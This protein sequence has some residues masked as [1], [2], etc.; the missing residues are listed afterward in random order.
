ML[1]PVSSS[2]QPEVDEERYVRAV[3]YVR[4]TFRRY[5]SPSQRAVDREIV[6]VLKKHEIQLFSLQCLVD[7]VRV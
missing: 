6:Q 2:N 3:S 7:H 4:E 5:F 1:T